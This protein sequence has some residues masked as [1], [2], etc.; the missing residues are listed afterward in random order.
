LLPQTQYVKPSAQIRT[1]NAEEVFELQ[2]SH[3]QEL[4]LDDLVE[5]RKQSAFEEAE[6]TEPEYKERTVTVLNLAEGRGLIEADVKVFQ[7]VDSNEQ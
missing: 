7:D 5:I 3:D 6:E 4:T 2:N 1:Y